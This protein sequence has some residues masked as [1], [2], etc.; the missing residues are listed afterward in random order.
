MLKMTKFQKDKLIHKICIKF[1]PKWYKN[2]YSDQICNRKHTSGYW[3]DFIIPREIAHFFPTKNKVSHLYRFLNFYHT[4]TYDQNTCKHKHTH[5]TDKIPNTTDGTTYYIE[6]IVCDHCLKQVG[7]SKV[8]ISNIHI[9][10]P[11]HKLRIILNTLLVILF[12]CIITLVVIFC[13]AFNNMLIDHKCTNMPFDE[14]KRLPECK[15]YLP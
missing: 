9:P 2:K 7:S 6:R 1:I 10:E 4:K 14:A 13:I 5:T 12:A 11:N 15:P 8:F 3:F